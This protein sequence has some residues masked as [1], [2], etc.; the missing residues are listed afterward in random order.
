MSWK[1]FLTEKI[2]KEKWLEFPEGHNPKTCGCYDC[3]NPR[4]YN[5]KFNNYKDLQALYKTISKDKVDWKD[6]FWWMGVH[7]KFTDA[8]YHQALFAKWL[9]C[10]DGSLEDYEDRCKSVA[11]YYGWCDKKEIKYTIDEHTLEKCIQ[12][13]YSLYYCHYPQI[14]VQ[15]I[16]SEIK[17]QCKMKE[18][19]NH[20]R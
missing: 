2:L 3:P 14:I 12:N 8:P 16:I 6:F 11:K 15:S 4:I 9:F 13:S 18:G 20:D 19:E 1:K 10:T 7:S 17:K 5:R